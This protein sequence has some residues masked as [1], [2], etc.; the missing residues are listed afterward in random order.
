MIFVI[1]AEDQQYYLESLDRMS[2][3]V[4]R[5][6]EYNPKVIFDIFIHKE[7]CHTV[8]TSS[9]SQ[10]VVESVTGVWIPGQYMISRIRLIG[11]MM[12]GIMK[13]WNKLILTSKQG[14]VLKMTILIMVFKFMPPL[15]S[16]NVRLFHI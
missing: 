4:A 13:F 15:P 3:S 6:H 1:D 16:G 2:S 7:G 10:S 14:E 9:Q 12:I 11:S 5:L 8:G